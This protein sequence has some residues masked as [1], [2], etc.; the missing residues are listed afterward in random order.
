L[1][2]AFREW[3]DLIRVRP[4]HVDFWLTLLR[5]RAIRFGALTWR[6]EIPALF[7]PSPGLAELNGLDLAAVIGKL[8]DY[9]NVPNSAVPSASDLSGI[10][11]VTSH[12]A[13]WS[14]HLLNA[15]QDSA[16]P[17]Q[18][19]TLFEN[20]KQINTA[21]GQSH[22]PGTSPNAPNPPTAAQLRGYQTA[23]V[24]FLETS[25]LTP[26]K[27]FMTA[28]ADSL[29][30]GDGL[31]YYLLFAGLPVF[32]HGT[33][34][35]NDIGLVVL[36]AHRSEALQSWYKCLWKDA[37]PS[38]TGDYRT[39]NISHANSRQFIGMVDEDH[40]SHRAHCPHPD[41]MNSIRKRPLPTGETESL[42]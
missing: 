33:P 29:E 26:I 21:L 30:T 28:A 20:L 38:A 14:P 1:K 18:R 32:V 37:L 35:L 31:Y 3:A 4:L 39:A 13:T 17:A 11:S 36:N 23:V 25:R 5:S 12:L 16:T 41:Y 27:T 15:A 7:I 8:K 6:S 42:C 10:A 19:T 22:V 34:T 2:T 24:T 9:F 40:T